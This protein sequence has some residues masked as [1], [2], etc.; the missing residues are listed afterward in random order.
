[1][2]SVLIVDDQ[3]QF[4]AAAK[5][6]VARAPGFEVVE[7]ADNG[8][9]ALELAAALDVDMVLMDIQMPELD[10]IEAARRMRLAHPSMLIVL[11]SSYERADLPADLTEG[12]AVV[13]LP[14]EELSPQTVAALWNRPAV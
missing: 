11:M 2:V 10:G 5:A 8:A 6:V 12:G 4:L 7:V 13:F 1:M 3:P 14:K 9:T